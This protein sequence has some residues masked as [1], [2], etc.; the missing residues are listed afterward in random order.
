MVAGDIGWQPPIVRQWKSISLQWFRVLEMERV[1]LNKHIFDWCNGQG[2]LNCKNWCYIVRQK[3]DNLHLNGFSDDEVRLYRKRYAQ[4]ISEA[5]LKQEEILWLTLVDNEQG[6]SGR[7]Q[8]KLRTY[9]LMKREYKTETYCLSRLPL[10]HRSA[11]AK[12]RCRVAP[13]RIETGLYE[14][15]RFK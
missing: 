12:F 2:N 9:R 15:F 7:G 6:V 4:E 14:G 1:R 3:F 10:K 5:L 11:F 13:I 8:N